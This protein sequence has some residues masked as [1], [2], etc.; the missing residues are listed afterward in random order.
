M[1][2]N[3]EQHVRWQEY[4]KMLQNLELGISTQQSELDLPQASDIKINDR[5]PVMRASPRWREWLPSTVSGQ[6][7]SRRMTNCS[8]S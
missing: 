3:Y 2:N 7:A 5:G 8:P 4:C 6:V 1:C